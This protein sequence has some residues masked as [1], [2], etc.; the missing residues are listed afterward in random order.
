M[1]HDQWIALTKDQQ[2][3]KVAKLCG[4]T[5]IVTDREWERDGY[6]FTSTAL[7][8]TPNGCVW[9][10]SASLEE[11]PDYLHDLNACHKF[12]PTLSDEQYEQYDNNLFCIFEMMP[13]S[14][15]YLRITSATA[16]Q[17]CEAF[18]MTMEPEQEKV[19]E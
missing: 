16:A 17:R 15:K 3:I 6:D 12:E 10:G 5:N 18:V 2:R 13:E 9:V 11:V 1:T 4:W 7:V 14:V 19:K 8:G